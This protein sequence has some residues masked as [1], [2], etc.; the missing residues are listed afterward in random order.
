M[1]RRISWRHGSEPE[2][3]AGAH[4]RDER[5]G[6]DAGT[7]AQVD[8][9]GNAE[10]VKNR[11]AQSRDDQAARGPENAEDHRLGEPLLN[12]LRASG[13]DRHSDRH[14]TPPR[15]RASEQQARNVRARDQE[16][17]DHCRREQPEHRPRPR[18]DAGA[19]TER[20][21]GRAQ[22]T[23]RFRVHRRQP[24][25]D[26]IE[27]RGRVRDGRAILHAPH[28]AQPPRIPD[29]EH[30][31]AP[32]APPDRAGRRR[33][34]FLLQR[35]GDPKFR[36]GA[37]D[38]PRE[39]ARRDAD[40]P[41]RVA[42]QR[43]RAADGA[44]VAAEAALPQPVRQHR[45][46]GRR[47]NAVLVR[48]ECTACDCTNSGHV[49]VVAAHDLAADSLGHSVD[50]ERQADA[51]KRREAA[52]HAAVAQVDVVRIRRGPQLIAGAGIR[53]RARGPDGEHVDHAIRLGHGDALQQHGV[54]GAE[55]RGGP[56][57]PESQRG[58]DDGREPGLAE[59]R[60]DG[61]ADIAAKTGD[62]RERS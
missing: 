33:A 17:Q 56:P 5:K 19:I 12:E 24:P 46:A 35:H 16:H 47:A 39:S 55:H 25:A 26:Y 48:G 20:H 53:R 3:Q 22:V 2:N 37:E 14:L 42:V 38:R 50:V 1:S 52:E 9:F 11:R 54:H 51:G 58:H 41:V 29:V 49:E 34:H 7:E 4:A 8:V 10:A 23:V 62:H 27:R 59:Q 15:H 21:G 28:H 36:H 13:A 60:P 31:G 32:Q 45:H 30:A 57:N 44:G 61:V 43:D 6:E 18:A 40:H